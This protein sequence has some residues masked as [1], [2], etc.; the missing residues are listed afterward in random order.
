M[1]NI[2]EINGKQLWLEAGRIY[3]T[4]KLSIKPGSKLNFKRILLIRESSDVE[5]TKLQIGTPYIKR[6]VESNV[7]ATVLNHFR[8]KKVIVY[9]MKPKK[10]MRRKQGHRQQL[11]RFM[12]DNIVM[13][14]N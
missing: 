7:K 9:K 12:V 4:N 10:K 3:T 5:E 14:K 6:N 2:V 8:M 1:Y 11:T 13:E